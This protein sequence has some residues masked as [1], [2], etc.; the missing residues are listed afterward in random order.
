LKDYIYI[1]LGGNHRG[2][3]RKNLNLLL[4]FLLSGLW[5]GAA[6]H[7]VFWGALHGCYQVAERGLSALFATFK[8]KFGLSVGG[9]HVLDV[10]RIFITFILVSLAWVFFRAEGLS[11]AFLICK[12]ILY[13]PQEIWGGLKVVSQTGLIDAIIRLSIPNFDLIALGTSC[14]LIVLLLLSDFVTRKT[15]GVE[16][17]ARC[18]WPI[19]WLVYYVVVFCIIFTMIGNYKAGSQFIYFAF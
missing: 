8:N 1:P 4:T 11:S 14:G 16:I 15:Y 9:K 10:F 18:P 2:K 12:K 6:W 3:F 7:F 19:R 17:I 5:H 13:L